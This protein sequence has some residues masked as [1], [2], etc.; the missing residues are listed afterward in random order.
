MHAQCAL[1][2]FAHK[3]NECSLQQDVTSIAETSLA[4]LLPAHSRLSAHS[5]C[6]ECTKEDAA[7]C[8]QDAGM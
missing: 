5:T 3:A 7:M 1:L 4:L 2:Q 8:V 6:Q